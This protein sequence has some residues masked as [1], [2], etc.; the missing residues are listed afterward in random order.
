MWFGIV[1]MMSTLAAV[2]A[3]PDVFTKLA[4]LGTRS[5]FSALGV[6]GQVLN[7]LPHYAPLSVLRQQAMP[8]VLAS[9]AALARCVVECFGW[10]G[11]GAHN[12]AGACSRVNCQA[13]ER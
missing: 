13:G 5:A 3:G 6:G 4:R 1:H 10:Q 2:I 11:A 8:C 12:W 9:C 7:A